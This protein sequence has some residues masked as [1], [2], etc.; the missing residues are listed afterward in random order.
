M[1]D[2]ARNGSE[3]RLDAII[4]ELQ[5]VR[6]ALEQLVASF[7]PVD[8]PP[9]EIVELREPTPKPDY[10]PTEDDDPSLASTRA[11]VAKAQAETAARKARKK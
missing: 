9:S 4:T 6:S 3:Q 7:V 2:P 5:G 10:A 11:T 1:I 8:L